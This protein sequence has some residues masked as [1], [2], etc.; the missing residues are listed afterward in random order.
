MRLLCYLLLALLP[1]GLLAQ[2][3]T[4]RQFRFEHL[5]VNDENDL[6][7]ESSKLYKSK[8]SC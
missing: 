7:G 2:P 3:V 8:V 5:T 1:A 4:P 6:A